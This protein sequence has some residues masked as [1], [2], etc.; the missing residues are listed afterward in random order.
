MKNLVALLA[1]VLLFALP[2]F[3]QNAPSETKSNRVD[4]GVAQR[5]DAAKN[6]PQVFEVT[7]PDLSNLHPL[8]K[9]FF[10]VRGDAAGWT[11]KKEGGDIQVVMVRAF[12]KEASSRE[13]VVSALYPLDG[14]EPCAIYWKDEK[15]GPVYALARED[16]KFVTTKNGEV[17]FEKVVDQNGSLLGVRV[18]LLS[19]EKPEE[20]LLER[21][22]K[23]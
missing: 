12:S 3:S 7:P 10:V 22:F 18:W 6:A 11:D 15:D 9:E 23:R 5:P 2:V 8:E 4:F 1:F 19:K 21:K 20:I 17:F 14:E 13:A 16:G